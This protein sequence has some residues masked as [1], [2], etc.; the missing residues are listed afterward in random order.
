MGLFEK[1]S[2][3][4][5]EQQDFAEGNFYQYYDRYAR[6]S[7]TSRDD[8]WLAELHAT[9][10]ELQYMGDIQDVVVQLRIEVQKLKDEI[11]RMKA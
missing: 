3:S 4:R 10:A 8:I 6:K 2:V 11:E 7:A 9:Y 1:K 5:E